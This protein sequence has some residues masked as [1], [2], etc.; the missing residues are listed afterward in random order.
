MGARASRRRREGRAIR[1][2]RRTWRDVGAGFKSIGLAAARTSKSLERFGKEVGLLYDGNAR[3]L[4]RPGS[5][6]LLVGPGSGDPSQ[7]GVEAVRSPSEAAEQVD[8]AAARMGLRLTPWQHDLAVAAL[9]GIPVAPLIGG[10]GAGRTTVQRILDDVRGP[11]AGE[12]IIDE[13]HRMPLG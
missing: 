12:P 2:S 4:G 10:K 1:K 8:A 5:A 11:E 13:I 3:P 6:V 7:T 9:A